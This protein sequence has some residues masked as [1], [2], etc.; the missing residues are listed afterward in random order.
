[1]TCAQR[2]RLAM[3]NSTAACIVWDGG[4]SQLLPQA[5][6]R[7]R[8]KHRNRRPHRRSTRYARQLRVRRGRTSTAPYPAY[9]RP[10]TCLEPIALL[11]MN[12][13]PTPDLRLWNYTK[14]GLLRT[15]QIANSAGYVSSRPFAMRAR[16]TLSSSRP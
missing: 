6:T 14:E 1:M 2:E 9:S 15:T 13:I 16:S 3:T 4:R 10:L 8:V 12:T 5:A 11:S 7:L